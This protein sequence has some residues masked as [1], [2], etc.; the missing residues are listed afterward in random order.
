MN[1]LPPLILA[2]LLVLSS[3]AQFKPSPISP[4]RS[5]EEFAARSLKDRAFVAFLAEHSAAD[6]PWNV[7]KLSLAAVYF[8][9]DVAL[10]RAEADEAAAKVQT[11]RMRPNPLLTFS[12]QYASFRAPPFT[13]WFLGANVQVPI[14]TAG[15]RTKRTDQAVAA[16]EAAHWRVSARTWAAR[17]RVRSAM[18]GLYGARQHSVLLEAEQKLHEEAIKKLTAQMDAGEVSPFEL[19]QARLM[20]NRTRLA[21]EDSKRLAV[22]AQNRLASAVGVPTAAL[23]GV[24][25]DF[26][27]FE[28]LPEPQLSKRR[29]LTQRADLLALLAEYAAAEYGLK[30]EVAKQYPDVNLGPGYD[31]NSGQNRWQLGVTF[32]ALFNR[33]RG[34]I[35]EAEARRVTAEKRFL[36]QQASIEGE[37]NMALASY[38][39]S[40]LKVATAEQLARDAA[41]ASDATQR[42]VRAGAVSALEFTRRQIEASAA[43][44]ALQ[45]ARIEAQIAAGALED[46]MQSPLR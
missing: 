22:S 27:S 19:T 23:D 9:P 40:R 4:G 21:L 33:N 44:M 1:G 46:S 18:L 45:S 38:Q 8:H 34:P 31:Y 35:A 16:A 36:A 25:L 7:E 5:S 11:A 15:K 3:C 29:A 12:P 17:S 43:N 6:L 14:E 28:R 26:A 39:A 37:L 30:L 2:S 24:D 41:A 32:P 42:M 10:A 13:P 20:L